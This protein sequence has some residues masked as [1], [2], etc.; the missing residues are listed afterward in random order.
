MALE[1]LAEDGAVALISQDFTDSGAGVF[2]AAVR[3]TSSP[4]VIS[5]GQSATLDFDV[6]ED[7]DGPLYFSYASMVLPS[8][9]A[10]VANGNPLAHTILSASGK[11]SNLSFIVAGS[12]VLD[13]G[14][15]VNDEIPENVAFLAQAAPNT[16]VTEGG[17]VESH[18]GF[19]SDPPGNI[20]QAFPGGDFT[21]DGYN[22][23]RVEV[24]ITEV[25]GEP[26][27]PSVGSGG[28]P[29]FRR[30][31]GSWYGT[32]HLFLTVLKRLVMSEF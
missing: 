12:Q 14:T 16:G 32:S 19:N 8:N 24:T 6:T 30:W 28:D 5:P 17:T 7:V 13:A 1:S 20:L 25:D 4:P 15:E 11:F 18:P 21:Q 29:H 26:F 31:N 9:D 27:V 10:F 2:Q 3:S 23:M 22:M